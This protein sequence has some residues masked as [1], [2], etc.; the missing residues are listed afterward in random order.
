ME[1]PR[2]HTL[3]QRYLVDSEGTTQRAELRM[4]VRVPASGPARLLALNQYEESESPV[5]GETIALDN[6][7]VGQR[8]DFPEGR[9][10]GAEILLDGDDQR[11]QLVYCAYALDMHGL[12]AESSISTQF[13]FTQRARDAIVEVSFIGRRAPRS[14]I[15]VR[16]TDRGL[17]ETP[18]RL[19]P[20]RRV[21]LAE[22]D[23]GPGR[24][25]IRWSWD[26]ADELPDEE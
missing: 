18:L 9:I 21:Q 14:F 23:F 10:H 11:G 6:C 16:E 19:G 12:P 24:L 26:D 15:A 20:G 13:A 3:Y 4:L 25:G 2:R 5:H 17:E 7:R 8:V 22:P 1:I